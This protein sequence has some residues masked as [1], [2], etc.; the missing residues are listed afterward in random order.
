MILLC[1][2]ENNNNN[3]CQDYNISGKN[4]DF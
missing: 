4:L 1:D 2:L 3:S